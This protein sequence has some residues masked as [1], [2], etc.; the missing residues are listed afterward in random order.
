[1][2]KSNTSNNRMANMSLSLHQMILKLGDKQ[3][4]LQGLH[5]VFQRSH[6]WYDDKF[7]LWC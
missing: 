5:I 1:M 3:N 7:G 6:K 4:E 2:N